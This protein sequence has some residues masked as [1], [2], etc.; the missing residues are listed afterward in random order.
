MDRHD[1]RAAH[2]FFEPDPLDLE[3]GGRLGG[4]IG[5]MHDDLHAE[6]LGAGHDVPA[7]IARAQNA[8][9]SVVELHALEL[10]L[11]PFAGLHR[12]GGLGNVP[13]ERN[14]QRDRVFRGRNVV[15]LGCVDDDHTVFGGGLDVDVV[16][17]D[18]G[19][20]HDPKVLRSGEHIFRDLGVGTDDQPVYVGNQAQQ[21]VR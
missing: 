15:A 3:P 4:Q 20:A 11:F 21:F 13:S 8:E 2:H 12:G 19:A 7:D 16:D 1:I 18:A 17:A 6:P 10:L 14:H 9:S 5:I